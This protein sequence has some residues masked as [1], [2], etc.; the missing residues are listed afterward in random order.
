MGA[1][2]SANIS[3][4]KA[5]H[6]SNILA[7]VNAYNA[8]L[9]K[10]EQE[11]L[12]R[13]L[14][15]FK[16]KIKSS[17]QLALSRGNDIS[18]SL[19]QL[20]EADLETMRQFINKKQLVNVPVSIPADVQG[21]S[22]S[23]IEK[24]VSLGSVIDNDDKHKVVD[25]IDDVS[26][27]SYVDEIDDADNEAVEETSANLNAIPDLDMSATSLAL[28]QARNRIENSPRTN[29]VLAELKRFS[30]SSDS[31]NSDPISPSANILPR[32]HL[33]KNNISPTTVGYEAKDTSPLDTASQEKKS[34]HSDSMGMKGGSSEKAPSKSPSKLFNLTT[35]PGSPMAPS[36]YKD[37]ASDTKGG[38]I[39]DEK[40]AESPMSPSLTIQR[41]L[42]SSPSPFKNEIL[43]KP[44]QQQYLD[45]EESLDHE[46]MPNSLKLMPKPLTSLS[47]PAEIIDAKNE[48]LMGLQ[49]Q[50]VW[51]YA[52]NAQLQKEVDDLQKQ[53]AMMESMDAKMGLAPSDSIGD[54][55]IDGLKSKHYVA[56]G[57]SSMAPSLHKPEPVTKTELS[58]EIGGGAA[59]FAS[60]NANLVQSLQP[61]PMEVAAPKNGS[62]AG[63]SSYQHRNNGNRLRLKEADMTPDSKV[64]HTVH[65]HTKGESAL[66]DDNF[67]YQGNLSVVG[68]SG[69]NGGDKMHNR[70]RNQDSSPFER[71]AGPSSTDRVHRIGKPHR[72]QPSIGLSPRLA[73][74]GGTR[75][76]RSHQ[77]HPNISVAGNNRSNQN[78]PRTDADKKA[79]PIQNSNGETEDSKSVGNSLL[80][81][82]KAASKGTRALR[83]PRRRAPQ[84][85]T[86]ANTNNANNTN[87]DARSPTDNGDNDILNKGDLDIHNIANPFTGNSIPRGT[88]TREVNVP[89]DL[90]SDM[91]AAQAVAEQSEEA[92]KRR[93]RRLRPRAVRNLAEIGTIGD[94]LGGNGSVATRPTDPNTP[95]SRPN[96]KQKKLLALSGSNEAHRDV[97]MQR[98][99][100]SLSADK[101]NHNN[102]NQSRDDR[103]VPP[104]LPV[105]A[106]PA[107]TLTSISPLSFEHGLYSNNNNDNGSKAGDDSD[108]N[109]GVYTIGAISEHKRSSMDGNTS[110]TSD[111]SDTSAARRRKGRNVLK[112]ANRR[113]RHT[114]DTMDKP[115]DS[116]TPT[117]GTDMTSI[118][119]ISKLGRLPEHS[120]VQSMEREEMKMADNAAAKKSP[121]NNATN[122]ISKVARRKQQKLRIE[123]L[124]KEKDAV[125]ANAT[126]NGHNSNGVEKE[127]L[128]KQRSA[129]SGG[130]FAASNS[131]S[132]TTHNSKKMDAV[133]GN[134]MSKDSTD[135][136][137]SQPTTEGNNTN[138][139]TNA[140][141]SGRR[142]LRLKNLNKNIS[143]NTQW[144]EP[145]QPEHKDMV[146]PEIPNLPL[147]GSMAN[148]SANS[149]EKKKK[150]SDLSVEGG[151]MEESIDGEM[152][153]DQWEKQNRSK[154]AKKRR[155]KIKNLGPMEAKEAKIK[156][157]EALEAKNK[158]KQQQIAEEEEKFKG[159]VWSRSLDLGWSEVTLLLR[160]RIE[161]EEDLVY[162][163]SAAEAG[164]A[165]TEQVKNILALPICLFY[166]TFITL[167]R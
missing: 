5:A 10:R 132:P 137:T 52:K 101:R 28:H 46:E 131:N 35:S 72:S 69:G 125:A 138:T 129:M 117:R 79:S 108:N 102:N 94:R 50:K 64:S 154:V 88:M 66:T 51:S 24:N 153:F 123:Q 159:K 55:S 78:S 84:P 82:V 118:G 92:S 91:G 33:P 158:A 104:P 93:P 36:E 74:K 165:F 14:F 146:T 83:I 32:K 63:A 115:A 96:N 162:T 37:H 160:K 128:F 147:E 27:L 4:E 145:H 7:A 87:N 17:A 111:V 21:L 119:G 45:I 121:R 38:Y 22:S 47:T 76:N 116:L 8:T 95:R 157:R 151:E 110:D 12:D 144:S 26:V 25:D 97:M 73:D 107:K 155:N 152:S 41:K 120:T 89:R 20:T 54:L 65:S 16:R 6:A 71:P 150:E 23:E 68:H 139:N 61:L 13:T 134:K 70:N 122:G 15:E 34:P 142:P 9:S 42:A 2:S 124:Q 143:I 1:G 166:L 149:S 98:E 43:G 53:L 31:T 81:P 67:V 18:A 133:G 40:V 29:E 127:K 126:G 103:G 141:N 39:T 114:M 164:M 99:R 30:P 80:K 105:N 136:Q 163:I 59:S 11:E 113:R 48:A 44:L 106:A 156:R 130:I 49:R 75:G 100:D 161:K 3:A 112:N 135:T 148:T 62:R 57:G 86:N 19:A 109:S 167:Y 60:R 140:S 77:S 85:T 56:L 90:R 58:P